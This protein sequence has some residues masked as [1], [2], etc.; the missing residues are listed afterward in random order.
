VEYIDEA[1]KMGIA[2]LPPDVNASLVDFAVVGQDIRFGLAAVKGVGENAVQSILKSRAAGGPFADLYDMVNRVDVKAVNRKVYEAMI[3]C[4]ALD[5]L[6]GN[7]AQLLDALDGALEVAAREMRDR[8]MGQSS[9][10]GMIEEPHPS[11][12]PSLRLLPA[13]STMEQLGWEKETLGIFVSGHPLADVTEALGRTGAV[14]IRDL[15][16]FEDDSMVKIAGLVTAVR[17]TLTKAQ[18]QMLLATI[19]DTT[20]AIECVVFPKQYADLQA[21]FV[22]DAI[23]VVTGRL[24]L[25]ERRGSTPGE[26]APLELN[27]SVSEVQPFDRAAVRTA[28]APPP[29]GWHVTVTQRE[30]ID[31]LALLISEWSGTTPL[32]LHINGSTVQRGV[33]SDR[34]VRERLVAIVGE[35]NVHEGSP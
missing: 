1:K 3:K 24:R 22:E 30:H 7:R 29:D 25:R 15:R 19:E 34:R 12:K 2:V 26:E 5:P 23:V 14:P 20:G 4:G 27:V 31:G 17:R 8:E 32:V 18:A 9:L 13:P 35:I 10:F 16:N 21:R 33:A 28:V 6:P 11:L